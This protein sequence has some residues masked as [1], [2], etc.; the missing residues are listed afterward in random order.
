MQYALFVKSKYRQANDQ[1]AI[2]T[3]LFNSL[4]DS[5][6]TKTTINSSLAKGEESYFVSTVRTS[7]HDVR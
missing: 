7:F 1:A 2:D 6:V 3:N 4:F 5:D